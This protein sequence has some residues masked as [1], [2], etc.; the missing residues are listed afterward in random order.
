[1]HSWK[2]PVEFLRPW[3]QQTPELKQRA[4]RL[5]PP[6]L[7]RSGQTEHEYECRRGRWSSCRRAHCRP[8]RS[9]RCSAMSRLPARRVE[10]G[11]LERQH[12]HSIVIPKQRRLQ[13]R[14]LATHVQLTRR[15]AGSERGTFQM[16]CPQQTR[17]G[18]REDVPNCTRSSAT[19]EVQ[20][21][22]GN[23]NGGGEGGRKNA[24]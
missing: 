22:E 2:V 4:A 1:M 8:W 13:S 11:W 7:S 24:Q 12:F 10:W 20:K 21:E 9:R 16:G 19:S 6:P 17:T 14:S 23:K 15:L 18:G 3:E 5:A